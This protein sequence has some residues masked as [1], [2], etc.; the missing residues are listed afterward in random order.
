MLL[1]APDGE[2]FPPMPQN[3]KRHLWNIQLSHRCPE[4]VHL[5]P[6]RRPGPTPRRASPAQFVLEISHPCGDVMQCKESNYYT[7]FYAARQGRVTTTTLR[8]PAV[9]TTENQN[10]CTK[11]KALFCASGAKVQKKGRKE[12][13]VPLQE[14]SRTG[15]LKVLSPKDGPRQKICPVAVG[16]RRQAEE[17][18][19]VG[20]SR[21]PICC[22]R[23][24]ARSGCVC[25]S[26]SI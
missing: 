11:K 9:S 26:K 3:R 23:N 19:Q 12:L 14:G 15:I 4:K 24:P 17:T 20:R 1:C 6:R 2:L 22:R 13:P 7:P 10:R 25:K 5:L 18:R 21:Y 16:G 8:S